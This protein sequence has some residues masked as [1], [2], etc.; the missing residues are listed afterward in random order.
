MNFFNKIAG[1]AALALTTA[2]ATT[3]HADGDHRAEALTALFEEGAL[4]APIK[5]VDC[6]LSGGTE[7]TCASITLNKSPSTLTPGPFCPQNVTDGPDK[8]GIWLES[9]KV[10]DV[11][12]T[13]IA[14]LAEFYDD[15]F[16]NL[17]DPDTGKINVT[18]SKVSCDAAARPDVDPKYYNHCVECQTSYLEP[19]ATKTYVIPLEPVMKSDPG[20]RVSRGG[21]GIGFTGV[22]FDGP[23]PVDAILGAHTI[24]PFD[25]CG[26][27]VNL[28]EGY[29]VHAVTDCVKEIPATEADHAP[30]I[31]LA[32]D[33]VPIFARLNDE[34]VE[35]SDLDRCGGHVA[36]EI[37]YHYHA[38]A[39]GKNAI[40]GCHVAETGCSLDDP[41]AECNARGSFWQRLFG[42]PPG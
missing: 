33:G 21:A 8:S 5:L 25:D 24:A 39:P 22:R 10:Y 23:A 26:G 29:H 11:D 6:T 32:M 12:G 2:L 31:G 7:T 27:H 14:G 34:G 42:G 18:D 36:G 4:A 17:V 37:P 30:M 16:W 38:A 19:G 3:A 35:S 1:I 9:G 13:F 41:S 15:S 40:L 28:H 20:R